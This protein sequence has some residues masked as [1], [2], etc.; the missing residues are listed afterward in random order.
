M[1]G[2]LCI[3]EMP[4]KPSQLS[5]RPSRQPLSQFCF[6]DSVVFGQRDLDFPETPA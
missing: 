2:S 3:P 5:P 4:I 6:A 1:P